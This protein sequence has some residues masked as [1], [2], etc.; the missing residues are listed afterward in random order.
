MLWKDW[1]VLLILDLLNTLNTYQS[2]TR[3]EKVAVE[4]LHTFHGEILVLNRFIN[5]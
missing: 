4:F 3:V 2:H 5:S 1:K